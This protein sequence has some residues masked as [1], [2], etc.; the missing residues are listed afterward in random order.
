MST[1]NHYDALGV[2]PNA[3]PQEVELAFKG[4][5]SQ[6]HPDRYAQGDPEALRWATE[7]MQ[8]VN[9]AYRVLSDPDRRIAHDRELR[10]AGATN[11]SGSAI[12]G[13]GPDQARTNEPKQEAPSP[14]TEVGTLGDFLHKFLP[15][16]QEFQRM[17]LAPK[18]PLKKL[19]GAISSYANDVDPDDVLL[20]VD[21]TIWGGA[22]DGILVLEGRVIFKELGDS[23]LPVSMDKL[24]DLRIEDNAIYLRAR[25]LIK[26]NMTAPAEI[27]W[28]FTLIR[29][30]A[31]LRDTQKTLKAHAQSNPAAPSAG[32][33]AQ[34]ADYVKWRDQLLSVKSQSDRFVD[35]VTQPH[36]EAR[37]QLEQLI[38]DF[39][40]DIEQHLYC[41]GLNEDQ[42]LALHQANQLLFN[43]FSTAKTGQSPDHRLFRRRPND[44]TYLELLRQALEHIVESHEGR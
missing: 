19:S 31:R 36:P 30:Y 44:H 7:Q 13:A 26:L 23:R 28:V 14:N 38:E 2:R 21:D 35:E 18:I 17:Y 22:G 16:K 12:N 34:P 29:D 8:R 25:R 10:Q 11:V 3:S 1:V 15:P 41:G 9:E 6:Y 33:R 43:I 39:F 37:D 40:S 32:G 27:S 5:R 20:L 24:V 42:A 4:R